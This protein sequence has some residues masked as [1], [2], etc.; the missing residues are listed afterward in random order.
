[1]RRTINAID[2]HAA[3]EPGR[4]IIGQ[5]LHVKGATMAQ[6]L[7]HCTEHLDDLRKL[8]LREPRGYP[9]ICAV[10]ILPPVEVDSDFGIVV[11]EQGGFRPM[12]GSNMI[13]A[14]TAMVETGAVRVTEP[15]TE[16]RVD[17]AV[18][19]V[20]V[21]ADVANDRVMRVT[22]DNV[23]AFPVVLDHPFDLPEYGTVHADVVF[24]GQ[25]FVQA[26]AADLG[27]ELVPN[28]AKQLA[29]AGAVL[30]TVA[31]DTFAVSHPLNPNINRISLVLLCGPSSTPGVS[32]RNTNV[33]PLGTVDLENP[34]TW[35]GTLDR[36]P[37]GTGT[38]AR[39]A[40]L[41]AR[42]ELAIDEDFVHESIIG[43]TFTGRLRGE[44]RVG[45]RPGVL[46]SISG[47][48]W[49]TGFNQYVLDD[50]DPF[51]VGYTLADLWGP[52]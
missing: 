5:N 52:E 30:R 8:L 19:T 44:T 1:M 43:T 7:Q 26:K 27:V 2:V 51:P 50:D 46:P 16:L 41:H 40:G 37:C 32:A 3:G 12:S 22:F 17:T 38:S 47:R 34:A 45:D 31:A 28:A 36:S 13:C 24:G 21:R 25:F 18:G 48:G 20:T 42:G 49:V 29:R 39:M 9:G 11:L 10:L 6:R 23:P 4:V 33:M 35:I 15:V 14:V